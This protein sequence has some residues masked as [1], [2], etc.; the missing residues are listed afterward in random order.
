MNIQLISYAFCPFVHRSTIMLNEKQVAYEI[1]YI[2]LANKPPW[3]CDLAARQ[4]PGSGRRRRGI[5]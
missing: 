1:T 5:L 2:D 4:S 3:S